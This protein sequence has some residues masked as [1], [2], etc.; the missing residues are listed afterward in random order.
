VIKTAGGFFWVPPEVEAARASRLVTKPSTPGGFLLKVEFPAGLRGLTFLQ[1][2]K[3]E[4]GEFY[5]FA[6][7]HAGRSLILKMGAGQ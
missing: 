3:N 1:E 5:D 2:V 7:R 4:K 6:L